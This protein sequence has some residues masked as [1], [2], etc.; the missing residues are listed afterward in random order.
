MNRTCHLAG[1]LCLCKQLVPPVAGRLRPGD[2]E[3]KW[4][5]LIEQEVQAALHKQKRVAGDIDSLLKTT[6]WKAF[7]A[8]WAKKQVRHPAALP[9]RIIVTVSGLPS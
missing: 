1:P 5:E 4:E 2:E 3:G 6:K 7:K 9:R 8:S